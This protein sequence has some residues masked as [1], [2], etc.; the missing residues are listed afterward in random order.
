MSAAPASPNQA[1]DQVSIEIDGTAMAVPKGSM[2]IEA[3]DKA[4][5]PI[6]RFCYHKKLPIAANC[7]MCLV[8]V[9][10]MPKPAPACAT[11]VME[12]MKIYTQSKRALD[13]QRNVMEFLLINHPLDCPIC[14]QGGECELQD[15]A[16]G[17]GRSV[18]RFSERKR[19]VPD[20]DIGPLVATDMTR[21]IHCTRCVRF[22]SEIAGT[23]ELGGMGR[24]D[25][26]EI[27]TYIGKN[28]DSELSGNII[29]VCPVG[30][31]TN[32]PFRYRA[33]AWELAARES[34]GYHDALGSNLYLHVRRGE[35]M[36][37]V[38][39]DNESINESWL[40]D[41][42]RYSHAGL[43]AADRAKSALLREGASWKEISLEEGIARAA[44]MLKA[45]PGE[46][47]GL[48]AHPSTTLEEG[49][50]LARLAGGLG[51]AHVDHRIG[52]LDLADA[53]VACEFEMP[54]AVI[55]K[56]SA[57]LLVG[58]NPRH[59]API[60]GHRIRKAWK[61]GAK[62]SAINPI[63]FDFNFE[64]SQRVI[65]APSAMIEQLGRVLVASG[66]DTGM[67]ATP[68]RELLSGLEA[69]ATSRTIAEQLKSSSMALIQLGETAQSHGN[70]SWIRALAR[71]LGRAT[72]AS[73]NVLERGANAL[74]LAR[75]GVLPQGLDARAMLE[76]PRATYVL[77]GIEPDLDFADNTLALQALN[78]A[79]QV[80]AFSAFVTDA[81]K[82]S[83]NL[84]LPIALM[85]EIEG[86]LVNAQGQTQVFAAGAKAPG[87]ARPGWRLLRALGE[88][89]KLDGFAF[90]DI[91][92]LRASI[93]SVVPT[94]GEGLSDR[95]KVQ[96][97]E[98]I[99]STPIYGGDAV[100]RRA[101]PLQAHALSRGP[102]VSLNPE[103]ALAGGF[104]AGAMAR[105]EDGRGQATLPVEVSPRV[106]RGAAWIE[107][108]HAAT[109]PLA[110]AG[111]L[112]VAKV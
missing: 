33:R 10:K 107:T 9:E 1:P 79:K 104:S 7:R 56:A 29:D 38:P 31:L 37:V 71:A 102:R 63:D 66:A 44:Q 57:V 53:P 41:R 46:Q 17:Y 85:P 78:Q 42:D 13:S 27:G 35:V 109:A 18:S 108:G 54:L 34:V 100:V 101:E 64:L 59:E 72:G 90:S 105:V 65:C 30:A 68:L 106:P 62:I 39:R 98:R 24:G 74:G 61:A 77:Y 48:L 26:L 43:V 8:D 76:Q 23:Y 2:I 92:G 93:E 19:V 84:I 87:E 4:G 21:C 55:E 88:A 16:M 51:S 50:L 97:L 15:V 45:A 22:V 60:L 52:L 67:L 95:V 40:S 110:P 20:E 82:R 32:K 25:R 103:D 69:D 47:T 73:V 28:I 49:A 11:P 112:N 80:V 81:L 5:I 86:S 36:R 89:L 3:A 96:G 111:S 70:A 99:A 58:C 12:G 75:V 94:S 91:H 6:P 14:D 83:A